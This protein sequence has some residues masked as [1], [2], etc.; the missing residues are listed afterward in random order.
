MTH[1][2]D[3]YISVQA[4]AETLSCTDQY[5]YVLIREGSLAAIKIGQRAIRVSEKSLNEFIAGNRIDPEEYFAPEAQ[6]PEP[7]PQKKIVRSN[8]MDR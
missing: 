8:W 5:V 6:E 7:A 4:V 1:T 2:D 3:K